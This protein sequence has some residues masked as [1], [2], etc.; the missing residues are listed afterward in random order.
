MGDE[1]RFTLEELAEATGMTPRNVRAYQTRGLIP[2]PARDGRRSVY[3]PDHVRQILAIQRAR[4]EGASLELLSGV[5]VDGGS[6]DR[7]DGSWLPGSRSHRPQRQARYADL[8]P[9]L[10]RIGSSRTGSVQQLVEQLTAIGLVHQ[11]GGR[12]LVGR[13]LATGMTALRRQGFPSSAVVSVALQAAL[14]ATPLVDTLLQIVA[15]ATG[16]T[17]NPAAAGHTADL[18]ATIVRDALAAR[19]LSSTGG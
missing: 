12:T 2:R 3:G 16:G 4:A 17:P 18:A 10:I 11:K 19:L 9:L 15:E 5:V 8:Q 7:D 13:E 6:I 14:V 1:Q